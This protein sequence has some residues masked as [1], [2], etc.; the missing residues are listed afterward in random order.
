M[1]GM[2]DAG[3]DCVFVGIETP[4]PAALRETHKGQN[5]ARSI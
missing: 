1:A 4:S 2:V 5:L 3:F